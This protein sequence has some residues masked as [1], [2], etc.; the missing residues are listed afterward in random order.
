MAG[1]PLVIAAL[2]ARGSGKSA[3]VRQYL[4]KARPARL[5]VWDYM[6]EYPQRAVY[7]LPELLQLMAAPR[8]ELAYRPNPGR[9]DAEFELLC[10]AVR[11]ARRCTLVVEE[12]AFVTTASRAP[13]VWRELTLLGRHTTHAE[14]SI[15]GISQRPASIDK[16]F[17]AC[18]DVIHCGRLANLPDARAVASYVGCDP[19]E[20]TTLPDLHY[21]ERQAGQ[22]EAAHGVLRFG[23]DPKNSRARRKTA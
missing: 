7:S 6:H 21:I 1:K 14:A 2:G 23:N 16:D 15:I 18:A 13:P 22:A 10:R 9:R 11:A 12:L 5:V 8:W 20:L 19:R 17:L 3:W 4:S